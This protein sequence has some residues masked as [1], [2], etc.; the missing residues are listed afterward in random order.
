MPIFYHFLP[1]L[2]RFQI[3]IINLTWQS[4]QQPFG[5]GATSSVNASLID[6][7]TSFA[8]KRLHEDSKQEKSEAQ[9]YCILTNEISVL[10]HPLVRE[11]QHVAQLQ[12]IC[13]DISHDDLP[14]PA[15]VFEKSQFGDLHKFASLPLSRAMSFADRFRLCLDIGTGIRDLHRVSTYIVSLSYVTPPANFALTSSMV[16]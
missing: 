2:S 14:W 10:V 8:F 7:Q 1:R 9:I 4:A 12:G 6:V 15:L 3:E 5:S 13:W 16:I 11:S